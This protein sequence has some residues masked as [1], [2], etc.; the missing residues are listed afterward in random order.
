MKALP[1]C[2]NGE[3]VKRSATSDEQVSQPAALGEQGGQSTTSCS[4]SRGDQDVIPGEQ[5]EQPTGLAS[6]VASADYSNQ[7]A[8]DR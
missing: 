7:S 5:K 2:E 1:E 3:Q 4:E 6:A 8:G